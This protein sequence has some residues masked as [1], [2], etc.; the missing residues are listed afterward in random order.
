ML[1]DYTCVYVYGFFLCMLHVYFYCY[2]HMTLCICRIFVCFILAYNF[3]KSFCVAYPHS[4]RLGMSQYGIRVFYGVAW[5]DL[6]GW[7]CY[8]LVSKLH[9]STLS[10]DG[11][12]KLK[13]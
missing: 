3:R 2:F 6:G 8:K 7:G 13:L 1:C 10:L 11:S 4:L 5:L 9:F 12:C